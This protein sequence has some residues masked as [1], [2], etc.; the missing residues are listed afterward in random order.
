MFLATLISRIY[1]PFVVLAVISMIATLRS[2]LPAD[3]IVR[4]LVVLLLGMVMPPAI[5]LTLAVKTKRIG[6][7]DISNRKQRIPAFLVLSVLLVLDYVLVMYFGNP[8]L[9][10]YFLLLISCFIGFFLITIF[11]KISGHTAVAALGTG[12]LVYWF[13][14]PWLPVLLIV[15][16]VGWARVVRHD[17]TPAQVL[18]GALYAWTVMFMVMYI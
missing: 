9:M 4:F 16:L 5:L 17:H 7:W 15:P 1:D 6:N 14:W 10:Q 12:L 3:G 11:W 18:A 8:Y 2:G 13:G